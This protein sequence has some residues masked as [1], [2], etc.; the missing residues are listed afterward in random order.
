MQN[1]KAATKA[2]MDPET[3]VQMQRVIPGPKGYPVI[4]NLLQL[5]GGR[6]HQ[7]AANWA[8]DY[9][10]IFKINIMGKRLIF[11]NTATLIKKAFAR[12]GSTALDNR[13][14]T[15]AGA[16]VSPH[17]MALSNDVEFSLKQKL[18]FMKVLSDCVKTMTG[19]C[20]RITES[21]RQQVTASGGEDVNGTEAVLKPALLD[22]VTNQ[23]S[24]QGTLLSH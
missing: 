7:Q 10:K 20:E 19:S 18:V 8:K 23:V 14:K 3:A 21:F 6:V 13:P 15:F 1:L 2:K 16:Y 24:S 11:L 4:G 17:S 22:L 5:E 12:M 9:G